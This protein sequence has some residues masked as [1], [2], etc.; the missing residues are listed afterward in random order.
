MFCLGF[1]SHRSPLG[2]AC[3]WV[4]ASVST[5]CCTPFSFRQSSVRSCFG[6][7][8]RDT[9]DAGRCTGPRVDPST[10]R[11]LFRW[12]ICIFGSPGKRLRCSSSFPFFRTGSGHFG[13]SLHF[14]YVIVCDFW[15][16]N[17]LFLTHYGSCVACSGMLSYQFASVEEVCA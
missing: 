17:L 8:G 13:I 4:F 9:R 1:A 6:D 16:W 7:G 12:S 3:A 5:V 14:S 10:Q 2:L 11:S 15:A